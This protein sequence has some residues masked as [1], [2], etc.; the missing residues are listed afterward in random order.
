MKKKHRATM[1]VMLALFLLDILAIAIIVILPDKEIPH[2]NGVIDTPYDGRGCVLY[3]WPTP[4]QAPRPTPQMSNGFS[5]FAEDE[6]YMLDPGTLVR[7]PGKAITAWEGTSET[8]EIPAEIDG[9]TIER[10]SGGFWWK[11][12]LTTVIFP[13]AEMAV[14]AR[15]F[16]ECEN[17][18]R[19]VLHDKLILEGNPFI[20]CP[21]LQ[22]I[23]V[24]ENGSKYRLVDECLCDVESQTL[25]IPTLE[26]M[27]SCYVPDGIRR[28]GNYA[29]WGRTDLLE[30][31]FSEDIFEIGEL[32]FFKCSNLKSITLSG[33]IVS[34]GR[35][36]FGHCSS[37]TQASIPEGLETIG[38]YAF[39]GC[40]SLRE[41]SLPSSIKE[42]G[43][44]AFDE[45]PNVC[46]IV[47]EGSYAEE[48][49]K[50]NGIRYG[51]ML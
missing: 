42:I 24:D 15:A 4:T 36:A 29:Y 6:Y 2:E 19:V 33:S 51:Y 17:L 20:R 40:E 11:N 8:I 49:A 1:Y 26:E 13:D 7:Y 30:A 14:S 27:T 21:S 25:I 5:Y 47:P 28:I 23:I 38:K 16:Y 12:T 9:V 31:N 45:C 18:K 39:Y 46:L 37:L 32:A 44:S 34:I 22:E 41:I 3:E 50:E 43:E 10:L 48:W 35:A